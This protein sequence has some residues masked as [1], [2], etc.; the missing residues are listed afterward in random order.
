MLLFCL[1]N[2]NVFFF[3]YI[4]FYHSSKCRI[5]IFWDKFYGIFI[6]ESFSLLSLIL[7]VAERATHTDYS[8]TC[9]YLIKN[10][11]VHC[12]IISVNYKW[13]C[14]YKCKNCN[15][16]LWLLGQSTSSSYSHYKIRRCHMLAN[17]W[18]WRLPVYCHLSTLCAF[19]YD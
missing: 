15:P 6:S 19:V 18:T 12:K 17:C 11:I 8:L 1:Q 13:V 5:S 2:M 14:V 10:W 7:L 4:L 3:S 16:L 9:T